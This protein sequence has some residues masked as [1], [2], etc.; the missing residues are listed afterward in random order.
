[1]L[2]KIRINKPKYGASCCCDMQRGFEWGLNNRAKI[3]RE[4]GFIHVYS[5]C[6]ARS[7]ID[8]CC[9]LLLLG[10]S[11]ELNLT[12][13]TNVCMIKS[14]STQCVVADVHGIGA[15]TNIEV[16]VTSFQ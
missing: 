3:E 9:S 8:T 10:H 14:T 4:C 6:L 7:L 2:R 11:T 13:A 16:L 12:C 15:C 5:Y 1:M